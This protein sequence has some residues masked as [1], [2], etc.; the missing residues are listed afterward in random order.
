[1]VIMSYSRLIRGKPVADMLHRPQTSLLYVT[2]QVWPF[3]C[4]PL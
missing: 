3:G 4:S 2:S 1:M